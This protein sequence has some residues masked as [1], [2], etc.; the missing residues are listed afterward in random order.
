[1][2]T[3]TITQ[4][5]KEYVAQNPEAFE[6]AALDIDTI[7][8]DS[9]KQYDVGVEEIKNAIINDP[10]PIENPEQTMLERVKGLEA[11]ITASTLARLEGYI[12]ELE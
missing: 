5:I 4:A 2:D 12:K 3:L 9:M 6:R 8:D 10:N 11:Q 1:M 7:I